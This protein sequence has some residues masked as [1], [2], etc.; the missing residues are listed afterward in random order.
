MRA[1]TRTRHY[2]RALR[3]ARRHRTDLLRWLTRRPWLLIGTGT[4]ETALLLS[5]RLDPRLK[6]LAELKTAGLIGCE[7]CLDIG[8]AL[9]H[10]SGL[11]ERQLTD[12]PKHT[13][14]DAYTDLEKLVLDLAEAMTS[15]PTPPDLPDLRTRLLATLTETQYAELTATIAWENQRARLN[16]ALGVRPTGMAD[17]LTCA[18]PQHPENPT[19]TP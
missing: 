5:N 3:D 19:A 2:L 6:E 12:L 7:F 11:T 9:A 14:S 4:Y 16:K 13:T 1:I 18:L 10:S 17:G 15:T 8:S